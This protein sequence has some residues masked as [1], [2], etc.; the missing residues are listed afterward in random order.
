M[1]RFLIIPRINELEDSLSLAEEFGFGFEYNDFFIPDV[2]DDSSLTDRIIDI[3]K[4]HRLPG[5]CTLHGAFFD[6]LI[7]SDD[8]E[9]RRISEMRIR[10]SLDIARRLGVR[11]V[12]FHTNHNPALTAK[13]YLDHWLDRNETFWRNILG[14]YPD[15]HIYM[16]NM[17]DD[18]PRLL[19]ALAKRLSDVPN[20]GVC[21]DYAHAVIFGSDIDD[22]VD[23]LSPFV[24]HMHINDNDLKNDL[25]LAVGEGKIDWA[26]FRKCF[27][28]KLAGTDTVLIE[29]SS[30]ERQRRSAEFL[31]DLGLI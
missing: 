11:G 25:H 7:F 2:L 17:F 30:I 18:S 8:R 31:R 3:Y 12:V 16:E 29:T 19:A 26:H 20:F 27:E 10:Q 28:D 13:L 1:S 24:R 21:F 14:E 23:S 6:V 15:M 9:I 22:W 5:L 4:S